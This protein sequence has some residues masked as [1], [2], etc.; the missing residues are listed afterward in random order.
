VLPPLP[1]RPRQGLSP[2]ELAEVDR[3]LADV[4]E[5]LL[6][7]AAQIALACGFG[8]KNPFHR[9]ADRLAEARERVAG[10]RGLLRELWGDDPNERLWAPR[11]LSAAASGVP[12]PAGE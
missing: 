2:T 4:G 11:L 7:L 12:G 1:R 9:P 10:A 6:E 8:G 3:R 5:E